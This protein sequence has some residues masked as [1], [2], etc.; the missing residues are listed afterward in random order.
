M[1]KIK[2]LLWIIGALSMII[3]TFSFVV[4]NA[5][6]VHVHLFFTEGDFA[7]F[8]VIM[9]S[10]I[11]GFFSCYILLFLKKWKNRNRTP[12]RSI[13]SDLFLEDKI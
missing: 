7:V 8:L 2:V 13:R 11:T 10:F 5:T 3:F 12:S 6:P 9:A 4:M 1:K